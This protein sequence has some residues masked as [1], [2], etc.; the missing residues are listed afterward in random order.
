MAEYQQAKFYPFA[1]EALGGTSHSAKQIVGIIA[2]VTV[3]NCTWL[4]RKAVTDEIFDGIAIQ[5]QRGNAAM[6]HAGQL[7]YRIVARSLSY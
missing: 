4:S 6:V 3:N 2:D 5:I 1:C 7:Q